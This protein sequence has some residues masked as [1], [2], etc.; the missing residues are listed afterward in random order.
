MFATAAEEVGRLLGAD[1]VSMARYEPDRTI[2]FITSWGT[3]GH[4]VPLGERLML[5]GNNLNTIVFETGRPARID[6]YCD[7]SGAIGRVVRKG[8]VRSAVGAP[9]IVDGRVWGM[10]AAGTAGT[11]PLPADTESRLASFTELLATA[12][13]SAESRAGLGRLAEEQAALRRMATLV[14]REVPAEELF[15]AVTEEVGQLPGAESARLARYEPDGT[16]IAVAAWGKDEDSPGF[17]VGGRP[18]VGGETSARSCSRPAVRPVST[19]TATPPGRAA[20]ASSAGIARRS[21]ARSS[22]S[23]ACGAS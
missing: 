21:G 20:S 2:T 7:A 18:A 1:L 17:P 15:A 23:A 19:T 14:A 4:F 22:S 3:E 8:G 13:A 10:M 12:I 9:I 11:V 16:V 6:S 5:G